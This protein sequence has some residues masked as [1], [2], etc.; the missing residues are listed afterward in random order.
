[1]EEIINKIKNG[2]K[3]NKTEFHY[4]KDNYSKLINDDLI[5][6][7]IDSS[8]EEPKQAKYLENSLKNINI[9]SIK[10]KKIF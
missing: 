2:I 6:K 5:L 8:W 1:M 10:F 9:E 7:I 3:L 4:F